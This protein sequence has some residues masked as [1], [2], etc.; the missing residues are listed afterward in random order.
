MSE[1][2]NEQNETTDNTED[3]F[4]DNSIQPSNREAIINKHIADLNNKIGQTQGEESHDQEES[5]NQEEHEE[6]QNEPENDAEEANENKNNPASSLTKTQLYEKLM[7]EERAKVRLQQEIKQLKQSANI[8]DI[9]KKDLGK[10]LELLGVSREQLIDYQLNSHYQQEAPKD[11]VQ[12][13]VDELQQK[14]QQYEQERQ[15]LQHQQFVNNEFAKINRIIQ[16]NPDKWELVSN[17]GAQ[18]YVYQ[19]AMK[20]Y[21]AGHTDITYEQALDYVE[22]QLELHYQNIAKV[23]KARK[24]F[25]F[26][27][28]KPVEKKQ[29]KTSGKTLGNNLV[30]DTPARKPL[31]REEIIERAVR[32][33]ESKKD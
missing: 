3:N 14:L 22:E 15:Q 27:D 32:K 21:E 10:A 29:P 4:Q 11:P 33:F 28:E 1:T 5:Q 24:W 23:K 8:Q 6:G 16:D 31:T 9:A 12:Q 25:A 17:R 2:N 30:S 19:E 26:D 7:V 18:E 20:A 13:K